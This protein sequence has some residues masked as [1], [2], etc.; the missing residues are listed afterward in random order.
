L[1]VHCLF[2]GGAA[3]SALGAHN[4]DAAS[5]RRQVGIGSGVGSADLDVTTADIV[6]LVRRQRRRCGSRLCCFERPLR[7][8]LF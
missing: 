4:F 6:I 8:W 1:I 7:R 2:T 3:S 5:R